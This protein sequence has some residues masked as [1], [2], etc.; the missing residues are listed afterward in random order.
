MKRTVYKGLLTHCFQRTADHGVVFYKVSDYLL[1]F[2]IYC[3]LARKYKLR[4]LKLVLMTDHVHQA[5]IE[6]RWGELSRFIRQCNATFAREYNAAVGRKGAL[7]ETPFGSATKR[8]DKA[9][10]SCLI[11]LDNNPV[12]RK[13][14]MQAD[15]YRWN[16][17]AY[18]KSDHPF[19]EKIRLR[20]ASMP[21]R[22]ALKQVRLLHSQGRYL[23]YRLLQKLFTSL[24]NDI[25][26]EQL[27]DFIVSTYSVIR[28]AEAI[29][30]FG[31]YEDEV[32]AA[33]ASTGSEHD[34]QEGF[35]GKSDTC[36]AQM[37]HL[38]LREG[39][40]EDIHEIWT[41]S[42]REKQEL[43]QFLRART[44]VMNAQ[45]AAFLHLPLTTVE[46]ND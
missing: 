24:P 7:W 45:I 34:I 13:L 30:Y 35:I 3:M 26:R 42:R 14:V 44:Y 41:L 18:A 16:F 29:R 37:T 31:S 32:L 20:E 46:I 9:T 27:V 23:P 10:R 17:M 4:V 1:Y 19:S 12:E 40:L 2:T 5:I 38:L 15:D 11:Y 25:E 33:H 39:R 36:Y 43:F 21:L 28:Y 22:R 8:G 6:D